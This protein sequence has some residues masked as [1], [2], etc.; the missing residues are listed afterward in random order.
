MAGERREVVVM[1]SGIGRERETLGLE[2]RQVWNAEIH[3]GNVWLSPDDLSPLA[4][5][6]RMIWSRWVS[7]QNGSF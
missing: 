4:Q 3:G 2:P 5:R 6:L 1:A 7:R